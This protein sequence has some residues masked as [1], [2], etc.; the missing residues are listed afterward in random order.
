MRRCTV[1]DD[2]K[3]DADDDGVLVAI[4]TWR[5]ILVGVSKGV[6]W[7]AG[8]EAFLDVVLASRTEPS[9][10]VLAVVTDMA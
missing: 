6:L 10:D 8:T 2:E 3:S 9:V 4:V 5:R 7:D 1:N